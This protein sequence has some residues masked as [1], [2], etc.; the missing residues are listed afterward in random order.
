MSGA[1]RMFSIRIAIPEAGCDAGSVL[2]RVS[3]GYPLADT[4]HTLEL[5]AGV[6]ADRL[7]AQLRHQVS[8]LRS[9]SGRP[10]RQLRFLVGS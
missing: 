5:F 3:L 10:R 8:R 7:Q 9:R 4:P 2:T 6:A 1:G